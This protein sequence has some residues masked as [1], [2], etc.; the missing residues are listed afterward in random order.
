VE[1]ELDP[2]L[3]LHAAVIIEITATAAMSV[4]VGVRRS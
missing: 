1:F 2:P 4:R 3:L